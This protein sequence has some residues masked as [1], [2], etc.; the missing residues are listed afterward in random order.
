MRADEQTID[1]KVEEQVVKSIKA[2]KASKNYQVTTTLQFIESDKAFL[3]EKKNCWEK[4][5][6]SLSMKLIPQKAETDQERHE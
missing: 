6:I 5:T 4:W 2:L 1:E 3:G